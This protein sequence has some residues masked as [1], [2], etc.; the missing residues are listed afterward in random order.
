MR[1]SHAVSSNAHLRV[2]KFSQD[3]SIDVYWGSGVDLMPENSD[4]Y[5]GHLSHPDPK[6]QVIDQ[7]GRS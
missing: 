1:A 2:P 4:G 6:E 7:K 3:T 5:G